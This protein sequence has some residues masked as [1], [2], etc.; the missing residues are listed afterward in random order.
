M[1]SSVKPFHIQT[2]NTNLGMANMRLVRHCVCIW[3]VWLTCN[4]RLTRASSRHTLP[5]TKT[6]M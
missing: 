3:C 5:V 4:M 1:V 2:L 6:V